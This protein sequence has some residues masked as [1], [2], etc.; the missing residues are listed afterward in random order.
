LK[1]YTFRREESFAVT[2][3]GESGSA[4]PLATH[5]K[6]AG[7]VMR[8]LAVA[9]W[10]VEGRG[11]QLLWLLYTKL[12]SGRLRMS[13][14]STCA[15][16]APDCPAATVSASS[17]CGSS[18]PAYVTVSVSSAPR[19]RV[20]GRLTTRLLWSLT[21]ML[22]SRPYSTL[23]TDCTTSGSASRSVRVLIGFATRI[24]S[25]ARPSI[26]RRSGVDDTSMS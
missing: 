24:D 22:N 25:R 4:T 21:R 10:F 7:T 6:F 17:V 18:R 9:K 13:P 15:A 16:A 5:A 14:A 26:Q 2:S 11:Y 1:T 8:S 3:A 23:T 19:A 20:V 12:G